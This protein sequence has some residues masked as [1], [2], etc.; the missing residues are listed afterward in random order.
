M[1]LG[2]AGQPPTIPQRPNLL[3][4][5]AVL[6]AVCW[7]S[8]VPLL[9]GSEHHKEGEDGKDYGLGFSTEIAAPEKKCC[10]PWKML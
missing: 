9:Y 1:P 5:M 7:L 3:T 2:D 6:S 10:R 8:V 4:I